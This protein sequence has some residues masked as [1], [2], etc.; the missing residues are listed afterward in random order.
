[1]TVTRA[2]AFLAAALL[3]LAGCG[4]PVPAEKA[5]Y[6]GDWRSKEMHLVITRDGA[7]TP[8]RPNERVAFPSAPCPG[9]SGAG[10][11]FA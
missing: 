1:M 3:L 4:Q 5:N 8:R 2:R 9:A 6:V 10:G 7:G 11:M